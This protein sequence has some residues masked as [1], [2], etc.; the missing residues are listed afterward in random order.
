[1]EKLR[2]QRLV[3]VWIEDIYHVDK[4]NQETIDS[5]INYDIDADDCDE[6]WDTMEELG[7][8]DVFDDK[9]NLIYSKHNE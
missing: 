1:M 8:Y 4:I 3:K 7:S 6:I 5:A 9:G 2:V